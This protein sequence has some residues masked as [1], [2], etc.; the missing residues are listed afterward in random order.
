MTRLGD[1]C[2][3]LSGFAFKSSKYT[4]TGVRIIRISNVQKGYI[5]D[6]TPV[7]YPADDINVGN[8]LLN[9]GDLLMS[10]TGN[11]GRVA[12]LTKEF[13]PAALN[14]RVACIRIKKSALYDKH[15]LY[16]FFNSDY[17]EKQCCAASNGVAQKN[18]SVSW[19]KDY[20]LPDFALEEQQ[21][22]S[23][24]FDQ[25]NSLI[26]NRRRQINALDQ[27]VKSQFIEM[28]GTW[29]APK[30]EVKTIN[31][32]CEFVKDGTHQTPTYTDDK[33]NGYKFLSSKDVTSKYIDWSNIKYIPAELHE[34]LYAHIAPQKGDILL[35]KNGTTGV[36]AVV[37]TDEI[38]DIY[39]SLALLRPKACCKPRYLWAAINMP[40]TKDQFDAHLKGIGVPNLHLGE[41]KKTKIVLPP[42]EKQAEFVQLVEQADK[43]KFAIQQSIDKLETL[44]KSLMQQYFG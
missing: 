25:I 15:F 37:E 16:N 30:Y 12:I 14:Q 31:E 32:L 41:I 9:E 18:M 7:Y 4:D 6:N 8:F 2:E 5:E 11:V 23:N 39:V 17:F 26:R 33:Q 27:L 19:L 1:V 10:L 38:F 43:S 28:F 42:E 35:A 3:I 24:N 40:E 29:H 36:C 21:V 34:Q 20:T 22:I 13:L 44:K